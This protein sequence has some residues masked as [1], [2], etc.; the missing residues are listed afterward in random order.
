MSC[1]GN[2]IFRLLHIPILIKNG[3]P[4]CPIYTDSLGEV[5]NLREFVE[6]SQDFLYYKS[7][8]THLLTTRR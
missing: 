7:I 2:L 4:I 3:V 6:L 1:Q 5:M 8:V